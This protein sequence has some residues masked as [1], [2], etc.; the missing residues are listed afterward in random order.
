[1]HA[2]IHDPAKTTSESDA[3]L[4]SADSVSSR[5]MGEGYEDITLGGL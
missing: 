4:Q 1:M 3:T 5:V 2:N